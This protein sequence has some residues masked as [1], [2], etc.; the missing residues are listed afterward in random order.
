MTEPNVLL[1]DEPTND[2]DIQT[3]TILEEY[4]DQFPGVVITVS[5]DRYFL[6]RI[7]DMLFVFDGKSS[8]NVVYGNYTDYLEKTIAETREIKQQRR[9]SK[10]KTVKTKK[11]KLFYQE[12]KEYDSNKDNSES[13]VNIIDKKET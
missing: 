10:A 4:I 12:Q 1:L 5:H 8:I 6:D 11:K 9:E 7:A 13:I 2:L 3:L